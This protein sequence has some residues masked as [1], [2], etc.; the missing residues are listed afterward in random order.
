MRILLRIHVS[1]GYNVKENSVLTWNLTV[2]DLS[3]GH[4]NKEAWNRFAGRGNSTDWIVY[5]LEAHRR[6]RWP[7]HSRCPQEPSGCTKTVQLRGVEENDRKFDEKNKLGEGGFGMVYKGV[8]PP[9][10]ESLEIAVKRFNRD[11]MKSKDDLLVELTIIYQLR[12]RNLVRLLGEFNLPCFCFPVLFLFRF[13]CGIWFAGKH[14]KVLEIW[15]VSEISSTI[16]FF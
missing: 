8:Q 11:K 5:A 14:A 4:N 9:K 15:L 16:L 7:N 13:T 6:G 12:H 10:D 3:M 2:E 1:T